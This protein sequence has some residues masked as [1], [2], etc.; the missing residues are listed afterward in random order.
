MA[1]LAALMLCVL[2]AVSGPGSVDTVGAGAS[3]AVR[4]AHP[5]WGHPPVLKHPQLA[6]CAR[7]AGRE[8]FAYT[9]SGSGET[10]LLVLGGFHMFVVELPDGVRNPGWG[11]WITAVGPMVRGRFGLREVEAL[12]A[13]A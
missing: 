8:M 13:R 9:Q 10:H 12:W 3:A 6:S 4:W 2:L 7:V 11:S 1:G 5:C